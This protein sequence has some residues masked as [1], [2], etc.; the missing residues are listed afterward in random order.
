[1]FALSAKL[2]F[3]SVAILAVEDQD[4]FSF[5]RFCN[6]TTPCT[7]EDEVCYRWT[8][9]KVGYGSRC[10]LPTDCLL[11]HKCINGE[12]V[13]VRENDFVKVA[14]LVIVWFLAFFLVLCSCLFCFYE[15]R[16][17]Q[18]EDSM[19]ESRTDTESGFD[20]ICPSPSHE[21]PDE[22]F[23]DHP[24]EMLHDNQL[25]PFEP[26]YFAPKPSKFTRH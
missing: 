13:L 19:R 5:T 11:K 23:A 1:M 18:T 20:D 8:C 14:G 22:K 9:R 2:L 25:E 15:F 10:T 21:L 12:C 6:S 17:L 4:D 3:L 24:Y 16:R 7:G 26:G